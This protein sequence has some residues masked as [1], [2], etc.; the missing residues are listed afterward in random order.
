MHKLRDKLR[1]YLVTD[2]DMA[3]G[4]L[5]QVVERAAAA[6]VT[7]VQLREKNADFNRFCNYAE[8]MKAICKKYN[9]PLIINDNVEVCLAVGAD[10]V[11]LGAEDCDIA[12]ARR[13]L[14]DDK[15]IGKSARSVEAAIQAQ[16]EGADY[17][18]VGAVFGTT[19][20]MDA[21]AISLKLLD[22]ICRAVDIPVVAIGGIGRDNILQLKGCDIAGVAVVSAIIKA[23]NVEAATKDLLQK[24]TDVLSFD[25]KTLCAD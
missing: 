19:T 20:K 17:L 15:I 23:Q 6:G 2:R 18:G 11:H 16:K 5:E 7:I 4:A 8:D 13:L 14:G 10:G 12:A 22:D 9:L 1:L 24:V 25:K 3:V 21:Q